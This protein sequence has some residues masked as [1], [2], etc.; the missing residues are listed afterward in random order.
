M[1]SYEQ[2]RDSD[3]A[4]VAFAVP[5]DMHGRGIATLLLEHLVS[6]ARQRGLRAFKASA[7]AE[8][9]S[10]L[11]VFAD[12][13]LPVRRQVSEGVVEVTFP[14]PAGDGG[15]SLDSYLDTVATRESRTGVVSLRHLLQPDSVAV[16]G[17]SRRRGTIGREILHNIVTG[18]FAGAVYPVNPSASSLEG[19][20]CLPSVA[21]LPEHV[22]LAVIAV[23][24]AA[25]AE[26]AEQCG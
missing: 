10:M 23:P 22:D 25:L 1:A 9:R 8:N 19:L 14:L 17:A 2:E 26:V 7:L 18:G 11:R 6:V 13:G 5:D 16:V 21:S 15:H 20:R 4:E 12:A 3:H 24:R